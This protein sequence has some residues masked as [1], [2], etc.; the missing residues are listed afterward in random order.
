MPAFIITFLLLITTSG[1]AYASFQGSGKTTMTGE[2]VEAACSIATDDVLQ[3][4]NFGA[5]P[6]RNFTDGNEPASKPFHIRLE[7]CVL[8]KNNGGLWKDVIV[9]FDG[10]TNTNN[11]DI[12]E[13][14][15]VGK[16][17]GVRITDEAGNKVIP[18]HALSAV[19]LYENNTNLHF[20]IHLARNN[21][22]LVAGDVSSFIRFMVAYQ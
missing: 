5:V 11:I 3:E 12:F 8:E 17:I 13:M 7:N 4:V 2:I 1:F 15:G 21:D 20:N 9:T 18:G 6:L 10:K 22:D 19:Q 16:G 14:T